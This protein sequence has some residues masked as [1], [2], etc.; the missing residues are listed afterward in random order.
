MTL[1]LSILWK[2]RHWVDLF[3]DVCLFVSRVGLTFAWRI[4]SVCAE[5][6][7]VLMRHG[8]CC[9]HVPKGRE[10]PPHR[11]GV[12]ET[13]THLFKDIVLYLPYVKWQTFGG[14]PI[15]ELEN[16]GVP[17]LYYYLF[18]F[19]HVY[20]RLCRDHS[21]MFDIPKSEIHHEICNLKFGH[22]HLTTLKF[23]HFTNLNKLFYLWKFCEFSPHYLKVW[24]YPKTA[25][26]FGHLANLLS[27]L[28]R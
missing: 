9:A 21:R 19:L 6:P 25:L 3:K 13:S 1:P 10:L 11:G 5:I 18:C 2:I 14:S 24:P 17:G 28:T 27:I 4:E 22:F 8:C 16:C 7:V 20:F 23:E 12:L 15:T 26:N